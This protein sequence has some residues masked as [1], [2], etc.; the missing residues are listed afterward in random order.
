MIIAQDGGYAVKIDDELGQVALFNS[1]N[2]R[3]LV[4]GLANVEEM[5]DR[6]HKNARLNEMI[7]LCR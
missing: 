6:M 2:V 3:I 5:I 7:M 4:G 1:G